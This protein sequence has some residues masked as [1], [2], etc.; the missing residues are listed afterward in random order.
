MDD[1]Q[2]R[3]RSV[4]GAYAASR[5]RAR[6]WSAS[7]AGNVAIRDELAAAVLP[8]LAG[9][10]PIADLGCGSGW[11]LRR[12]AA[13]GVPE[14]Q[15][16]GI[17]LLPERV[18]A[19]RRQLAGAELVVG[20]ARRLPWESGMFAAATMFTTLSSAPD[21][22]A[23][24]QMLAEAERVLAPGGLLFVWEPR[25]ANPLNPA[26]TLLRRATVERALGPAIEIRPLTLAAPLARSLGRFRGAYA[27]LARLRPLRSHRLIRYEKP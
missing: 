7:N 1:E 6:A 13:A 8:E 26:T 23:Q 16:H 24:A 4:Y 21:A 2:R 27:M 18:E 3:L 20:D 25:I 5:R 12:L 22:G 17:D 14:A 10:A 15:L 11:W 19:A 9:R